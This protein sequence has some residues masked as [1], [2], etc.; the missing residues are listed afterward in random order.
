MSFHLRTSEL[1]RFLSQSLAL[2]E[3][4]ASFN[5]KD[6][7]NSPT[8]FTE[9]T[10]TADLTIKVTE[11]AIPTLEIFKK[12]IKKLKTIALMMVILGHK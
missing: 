12:K 2:T 5:G 11:I 1:R 10:C 9:S 3:T 7:L 6:D 4:S 8:L